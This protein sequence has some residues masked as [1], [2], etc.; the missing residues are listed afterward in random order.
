MV[1]SSLTFLQLFLPVTMITYYITPQKYRN[2]LLFLL[3]LIF[4]AWGEPVY[5]FLMIFSTIVDYCCGLYADRYRG[6]AK[7]KI[8]LVA[9]VGINLSLLCLFKYSDLLISTANSLLGTDMPIPELPLPIGISFYTF[10][11][12]S[13]TIDV[14]RGD[15]K[16]QKNIISFGAY[17]AL[18]PQLIAGPIIRYQTVAEQIESRIQTADKFCEGVKRFIL[19]L[20]KKV[21]LANNIGMLW[22]AVHSM[23]SYQLSVF[24]VWLGLAAYG[25]QIYF[26]FSGYSDMAIG[27][28]KMLG[29]DFPENF[30]YPFIS[31]SITEFWR[32]WH[33]S[34]GVW[35]RDYVYI[36]LGGNRCGRKKQLVNIAVVWLMTGLWHGASWNFLI[37]G[38]VFGAL[39]IAEKYF[40]LGW[41]EKA[42]AAAGHLYTLFFV[43]LNWVFF[44]FEDISEGMSFLSMMFGRN[45]P[46]IN[47]AGLY[48]LS[49]YGVLLAVCAAAAMPLG[50][51]AYAR[52]EEGCSS[53]CFAVLNAA[54]AVLIIALSAAYL[55]SGSYNPFLYFRF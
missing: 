36:P 44:V 34:L 52:L 37:W 19:G 43:T 40:M 42:P 50:K 45:V 49:S 28:G 17:V 9:S 27:L 32:R 8:P 15:A 26:D 31:K 51:N 23:D 20:G 53:K 11:T 55:I 39:L 48:L 35:F 22:E 4:Y 33:I 24:T 46:L 10:Q 54:G 38:A 16:V 5:V 14:Y 12:M 41:L 18:F 7:A 47:S 6:T 30:N 29:F 21:I 3:S 2:G 25:L 1:F 13:Y